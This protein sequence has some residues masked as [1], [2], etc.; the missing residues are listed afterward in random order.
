MHTL[1]DGRT[2][3]A[4]FCKNGLNPT[5][6]T[7]RDII[8]EATQILMQKGNYLNTVRKMRVCV[9][10]FVVPMPQDVQTVLK[11]NFDEHT[12]NVWSMGYEFM[13]GGPGTMLYGNDSP[14]SDL[15]DLGD[16]YPTFWAIGSTARQV[17]AFSTEASDVGK[18][19]RVQG[20]DH[21]AMKIDQPSG[22]ELITIRQWN[23]G[24]EGSLTATII[25]SALSTNEFQDIT[26]V[27]KPETEGYVTLYAY[28]PDSFNMWILGKYEPYET[29]PGYR[30]YRITSTEYSEAEHITALVKLRYTPAILDTDTLLIQHLPSL[31]L[32]CKSLHQFDHGD[33][34]KGMIYQAKAVQMLDEQLRNAHPASNELDVDVDFGFGDMQ[35]MI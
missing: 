29:N 20:Y 31:K 32:M 35:G 2:F 18:T 7:V 28:D 17:M 16:G 5:D 11:V 25:D 15:I 34:Q 30:R 9:S 23:G 8:N 12:A 21:L 6:D 19:I 33:P 13:D 27:I 14:S 1:S 3:C 10:N 4:E 26:S 22:G 24:E